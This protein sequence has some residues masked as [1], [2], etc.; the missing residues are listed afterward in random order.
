MNVTAAPTTRFR[1]DRLFLLLLSGIVLLLIVAGISILV[2]GRTPP[3]LPPDSPGRTVQQFYEALGAQDYQGAYALLSD[4]MVAKPTREEFVRYNADRGNTEQ[5]T[6]R[7]RLET[8]KINGDVATVTVSV[9]IHYSSG[10][11][12][13]GN[14]YTMTETFSLRHDAAGW[15]ISD[16]P[17]RYRPYPG[18]FVLPAQVQGG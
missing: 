15:R 13:G 9:I 2:A 17:Y 12:F 5:A 4:Q 8:E 1:V 3:A 6:Q 10:A 16:L 18:K 7:V 11:P 14:D